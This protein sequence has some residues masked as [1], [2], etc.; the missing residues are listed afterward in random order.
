MALKREDTFLTVRKRKE[1]R[2][3]GGR[4][5]SEELEDSLLAEVPER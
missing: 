4:E 3:G 1:E 2:E 5:R